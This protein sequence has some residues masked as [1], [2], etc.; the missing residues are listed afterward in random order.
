MIK[1]IYKIPAIKYAFFIT[2][3]FD[4]IE[5]DQEKKRN[6]HFEN[7]FLSKD[8]ICSK[9]K[10][11]WIFELTSE[12]E[13]IQVLSMCMSGINISSNLSCSQPDC[14]ELLAMNLI[15]NNNESSNLNNSKFLGLIND[16]DI[17]EVFI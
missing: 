17:I 12:N 5:L 9:E 6:K 8:N 7:I 16:E 14:L 1:G 3:S 10:R 2:S 15:K 11:S 4:E 13:L